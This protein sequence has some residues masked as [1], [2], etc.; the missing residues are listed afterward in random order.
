MAMAE[1]KAVTPQADPHGGH[2]GAG[3]PESTAPATSH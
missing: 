2:G 1:I 3:H